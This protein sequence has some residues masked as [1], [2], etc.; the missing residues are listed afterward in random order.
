MAIYRFPPDSEG[1]ESQSTK[2]STA[3]MP[4]HIYVDDVS[5]EYEEEDLDEEEIPFQG[6]II[7]YPFFLRVLTF[8]I[9]SIL[10]MCVGALAILFC[11][12]LLL[13]IITLFNIPATSDA[14]DR[15][16]KLI[17]RF[18]AYTLGLFV[19]TISPNFGFGICALYAI[20]DGQSRDDV[21]FIKIFKNRF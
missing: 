11:I 10:T 12:A 8:I 13:S 7:N 1:K 9:A 6:S 14:M 15:F 5:T 16:W 21:P 4:D 17:R 20:Q 19:A 18:S 3:K 2:K